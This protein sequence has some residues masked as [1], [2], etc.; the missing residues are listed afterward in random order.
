MDVVGIGALNVD[1]I[2]K[3]TLRDILWPPFLREPRHLKDFEPNKEEWIEDREANE[4][5]TRG[6]IDY[7]GPG[8]SAFNTIHCLAQLK[9]GLQ[10]GYV[11]VLGKNDDCNFEEH[12]RK[13]G[14]DTQFVFKSEKQSGKCISVYRQLTRS[15]SLKTAPGAN[16]ELAKMLNDRKIREE[17]SRYLAEAKWIHLS[18]F[19]DADCF[20][21]VVNVLKEVKKRKPCL[22]ISFDPGSVYCSNP[23][24][25]FSEIIKIAD[26]LFLNGTEFCNLGGFDDFDD[27]KEMG[28]DETEIAR[29]IFQLYKNENLV[30]VLKSCNSIRFFK[31]LQDEP[32]TW[33]YWQLPLIRLKI[34][35]DTGAGDIFAAG[36]IISRLIPI[37]GFDMRTAISLCVKLVNVKLKMLGCEAPDKYESIVKEAIN[38]ISKYKCNWKHLLQIL[39]ARIWYLITLIIVSVIASYVTRWL[40]KG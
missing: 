40:S 38:E 17:L 3:V 2:E 28:V 20:K 39:F 4:R 30:F 12:F 7:I 25:S 19:V 13:Y 21:E 22:I 10:L 32:K 8:G 27:A 6:N 11:G 33:R 37:L 34:S 23:S 18:S 16:N 24:E 15:R 29:R 36:F 35:D 26:Y 14:I 9:L 5:I 1:Y 31:L